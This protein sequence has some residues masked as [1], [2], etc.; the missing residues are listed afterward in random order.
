MDFAL[1]AEQ[2]A[3]FEMAYAFGQAEIAPFART[4]EA[5]GTI[6]TDLWPNLGALGFAALYVD[7]AAGGSG[8]SRPAATLV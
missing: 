1:S 5:D 4:W 3:I 8:L 7:E 2:D 6:P